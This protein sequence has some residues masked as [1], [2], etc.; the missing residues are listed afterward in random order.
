MPDVRKRSRPVLQ[1]LDRRSSPVQSATARQTVPPPRQF[2]ATES[3]PMM[4]VQLQPIGC[5]FHPSVSACVFQPE[6]ARFTHARPRTWSGCVGEAMQR[7]RSEHRQAP[8]SRSRRPKILPARWVRVLRFAGQ[9]RGGWESCSSVA[10]QPNDLAGERR[11]FR[12]P[13]LIRSSRG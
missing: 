12:S 6:V 3:C 2:D 13:Q 5:I 10:S 11:G 4:A 7:N 1:R 9:A 8:P